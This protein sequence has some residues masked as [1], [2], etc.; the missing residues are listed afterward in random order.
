[1]LRY[2]D[3]YKD[4]IKQYFKILM[5]SKANF[6]IGVV[7][8]IFSQISGILFLVIIFG[9]I[10]DLNGWSFYEILFIYGFAQLP[11]GLDHLFADQLWYF[12][13]DTIIKGEFDRYLLRPLNPLFQ[14]FAEKLQLDA[15]GELIIGVVI[16]SYSLSHLDIKISLIKVLLFIVVVLAGAAIYTSIKL[17]FASLSFW[18]KQSFPVLNIVYMFSDFTKYPTS[19]YGKGIRAV[20]S[21]IIPF[22]FTAFIP[23]SYFLNKGEF[24]MGIVLTCVIAVVGAIISYSVWKIGIKSYESAG[25]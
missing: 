16:T 20:L 18:I 23:A 5:Q 22:A 24:V 7:C 21:F 10:P 12:S 19:I 1:M 3:I 6:F 17:F 2:L 4:F 14:L 11:R 15:V 13:R 8:F 25:N 9:Q